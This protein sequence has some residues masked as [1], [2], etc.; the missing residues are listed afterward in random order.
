MTGS[1]RGSRS[2]AWAFV[3]LGTLAAIRAWQS[4][5]MGPILEVSSQ[6]HGWTLEYPEFL[7]V[8]VHLEV[9]ERPPAG[10]CPPRLFV[11]LRSEAGELVRTF[12]HFPPPACLRT[13]VRHSIRL[14]RSALIEPLPAGRYELSVGAHL[15]ELKLPVRGPGG[16]STRLVLGHVEL[17]PASGSGAPGVQFSGG[18]EPP[19]PTGN[20]QHPVARRFRPGARLEL[21]PSPAAREV[22]IEVGVPVALNDASPD[23]AGLVEIRVSCTGRELRFDHPGLHE[24]TVL[25]PAEGRC[26]LHFG[27]PGISGP[28]EGAE[29]LGAAPHLASVAWRE[30]EP[31][32][33]EGLQPPRR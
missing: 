29:G 23:A 20:L 3:A 28:G 18:W 25:V 4:D 21:A 11:H 26:A 24:A 8:P 1:Y 16:V 7:E 12:D 17:P 6:A 22:R 32:A 10:R 2:V 30:V 9:L 5:P 15:G 19:E 14:V 31:Q 33:A 27:R 13:E